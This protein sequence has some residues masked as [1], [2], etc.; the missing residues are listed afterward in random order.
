M[1]LVAGRLESRY[2]YSGTIVYN[3]FPFPEAS[4]E[5]KKHIEYLAEEILMAREG[6]PNKTLAELYDPDKMPDDLLKAHRELDRAVDELYKA[7]G[8]RNASERVEHLL[9]LYEKAVAK[10][11]SK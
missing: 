1:R 8:F 5:Q 3:T 7:G 10:D 9:K 11:G 6:Y 2:R 4:E